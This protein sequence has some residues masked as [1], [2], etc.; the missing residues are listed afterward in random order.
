[1]LFNLLSLAG[2]CLLSLSAILGQAPVVDGSVAPAVLKGPTPVAVRDNH[3][4]DIRVHLDD[5]L[6][7]APRLVHRIRSTR[8]RGDS[9]DSSTNSTTMI[10][11]PTTNP[12]AQ[13]HQCDA[14]NPAP[15]SSMPWCPIGWCYSTLIEDNPC[16]FGCTD[17][18]FAVTW[19]YRKIGIFS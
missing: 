6:L 11:I 9:H 4:F 2:S 8:T 15:E 19:A 3:S 18:C 16:S 12:F 7:R 1:M 10:S 17:S 13:R 5:L 14:R